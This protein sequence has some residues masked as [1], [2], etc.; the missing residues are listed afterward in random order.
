MDGLSNKIQ[1]G[2]I[3]IL[4]LDYPH[5]SMVSLS[6]FW[7]IC[8][9]SFMVFKDVPRTQGA[10]WHGILS[11]KRKIYTSINEHRTYILL[12]KKHEWSVKHAAVILHVCFVWAL[13]D[14]KVFLEYLWLGTANILEGT[15]SQKGENLKI[16]D[17]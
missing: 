8:F 4:S 10:L 17:R 7:K 12:I 1:C 11:L 5:T 13:L 2:K 16:F 14:I 15:W 9:P 3:W 6:T